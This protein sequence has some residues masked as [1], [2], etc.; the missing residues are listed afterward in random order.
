M[1]QKKTTKEA[2][3]TKKPVK[4]ATAAK[5][6]KLEAKDTVKAV[7]TP[8][9]EKP[10]KKKAAAP[11]A[12]KKKVEDTEAVVE[13]PVKKTA[14]THKKK[15][16]KPAE[17]EVKAVEPAAAVKE[18]VAP[19]EHKPAKIEHK[20][21]PVPAQPQPAPQQP[22]KPAVPAPQKPAPAAAHLAAPV[23]TPLKAVIA[24]A[25]PVV[26]PPPA[27]PVTAPTPVPA[28]AAPVTPPA[29][30]VQAAPVVAEKPAIKGVV[31]I[32]ENTTVRELAEKMNEKPG[33]LLRKL[34]TM[35]GLATINQKLDTDTATLL[36]HEF[37]YEVKFASM[38]AEETQVVEKEDPALLKTRPPV[39]TI[40]GHVDHGK[41]SLLDAIRTTNVAGGEAGGITQHIGAYRVKTAHGDVAFLDTPGH[42]AFTAMRSRGAKATDL[43]VLV[44]S[45]ADGVMPQTVE[46][47][48][49][50]KAANVPIIVAMNK[51]DLPT[52]N[53]QQ[54]KQALS[55][56]GLLAEDWGGDVIMVEVSA[57]A[58]TGIDSLLEMILLK[59]EMLDLKANPDAL[60]RG[61]VVE[62]KL[63]PRRGPVA[64]VLVQNG[65][66]HIGDNFIVG[67]TMGKV[68]AMVDEFG[69][70]HQ[71]APPSTPVEVMGLEETPQAG[72]T[73]QVVADER[74]ARQTAESR[75]I[76]AR[77]NA[78]RSRHHLSLEDIS[79][80]SSKELRLIIKTDV[81][82]SL[83]A[84]RDSLERFTSAEIV[85]KIIHGGVGSI[86]ESDVTLA[87][88]SDAL[89]VGFNIRPDSAIE[90]LAEREGVNIRSYRII[91]DLI[92]DVKAA[93]EGM[94]APQIK[95]V[96]VGKA[97]VKQVFKV[98]KA[99]TV[100][101]CMVLEGKVVRGGKA[102][103]IR[104]NVVVFEGA[105]SGL[106][107]FKDDVREVEKGFECGITLENYNDVKANDIIE[108]ITQEN[109]ATKL[110][111]TI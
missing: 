66:L 85:L 4:A 28:P 54:V 2:V 61:V 24:A 38:Y 93:L 29:A 81:R 46:A 107:R 56:Y 94:L 31:T 21:P 13:K 16:V 87:A 75:K 10:V 74:I 5:T 67:N 104:D 73:F 3:V 100:A 63:D 69:V 80:R 105:I 55:G 15:E 86:N 60:A 84:L 6:K 42:E 58:K 92:N 99:G 23:V 57:R 12:P 8:E 41:T 50:A 110:N 83:E 70:R 78:L 62:A 9:G 48:D 71:V 44:V 17:K 18:T 68:R 30:P 19:V 102:R 20:Q 47:I 33:D 111:D 14:V 34:L 109:I 89:I 90:R 43:V 35:G 27:A 22:V 82:G 39:V 7:V 95:E 11:K 101:G 64:T 106:K 72:D 53:P 25:T 76:R 45:A 79:S 108:V 59:A 97:A 103:L 37:L 26:A 77:D 52:A 65:T 49:H 36:A 1:T 98:T 32:N 96:M 88:A 51:M 91:Y 40:M